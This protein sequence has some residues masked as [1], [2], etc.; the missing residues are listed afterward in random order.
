MS[1][2]ILDLLEKTN[3][4]WE[5]SKEQLF[6]GDGSETNAFGVFKTT[7][8]QH[9]GTVGDRY[10]V[11]QNWQMAEAL[12]LASNDLGVTFDRGGQLS[13]GRKVYLQAELPST[14]IG[15]SDVKRYITA[16]NSHDGSSSIGF[17]SSNV[18][19][20]CTNTFHKAHQNL[21]KFRHTS[22]AP[23]RIKRL[24]TDI[25]SVILQDELLMNNF[26]L[27]ADT[28]L[29]DETIEKV[30]KSIFD[31][32]PMS[33]TSGITQQKIIKLAL[34]GQAF[35]IEM[36]TQGRSLWGMFNAVTRYTNHVAAPSGSK[37]EYLMTGAGYKL[38][39]MTYETLMSELEKEIV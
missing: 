12:L 34:F 1:E 19:V 10:E 17:G 27:M 29:R 13:K 4:N 25:N 31:V 30:I 3:L 14:Y 35:K 11:Y 5:V 18:V 37:E 15:T 7:S 20:I 9:L 21:N 33:K 24:A 28:P 2:K 38:S 16:L 32:D 22:S 23:E 39:N 8:R 26:K 6:A 36:D